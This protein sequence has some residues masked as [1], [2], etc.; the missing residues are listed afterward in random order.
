MAWLDIAKWGL[1][2]ITTNFKYYY[3]KTASKKP[4]E[5]NY[6]LPREDLGKMLLSLLND[7]ANAFW[8][9]DYESIADSKKWVNNISSRINLYN[10]CLEINLTIIQNYVW[11][12]PIYCPQYYSLFANSYLP[13]FFVVL[14]LQFSKLLSHLPLCKL[15]FHLFLRK[16]AFAYLHFFLRVYILLCIYIFTLMYICL[17]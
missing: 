4:V 1:L 6:F 16:T 11:S 2:N 3:H 13:F 10:I 15:S 7:L 5:E 8:K 14:H 9:I 17:G 12:S